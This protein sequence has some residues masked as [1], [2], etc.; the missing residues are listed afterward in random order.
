[1]L[2]EP[3]SESVPEPQLTLVVLEVLFTVEATE[4]VVTDPNVAA[5]ADKLHNA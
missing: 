5:G 1:M 4:N 2:S 3:S